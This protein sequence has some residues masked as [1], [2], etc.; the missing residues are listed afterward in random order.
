LLDP[1]V[2]AAL[3]GVEI[4]YEVVACD[5]ELADTANFVKAYGY[6][7][8]DSAN[9]IVVVGKS[10]PPKY[11]ACLVLANTRLDVNHAV[12][13][14]LGVRASFA[15]AE[16]VERVTGMTIGGVTPVGI[17]GMPIW[18]DARVMSRQRIIIGGG[19]RSSKILAPP[20][21]FLAL[22]NAEVVEGLAT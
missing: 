4:P 20:A 6:E 12:K 9:A 21:L 14:R 7:L 13:K 18:I 10:N 1:R 19:N 22:P 11:V 2:Q 8:E 16:E 3:A 5:P 17:T 15:S